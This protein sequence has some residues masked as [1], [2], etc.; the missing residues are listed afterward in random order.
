MTYLNDPD[1]ILP[2]PPVDPDAPDRDDRLLGVARAIVPAW[3][4]AEAAAITTVG[5]G[6]TNLL[7]KLTAPGRPPLLARLYGRNTEV[8]I[9]RVAENRLFAQLSRAGFAPTY[10]GRF[11]G[12]RLEGFLEGF[13]PLE[14]HEMGAPGIREAL[15]ARLAEMHALPAAGPPTLWATLERWM[16]AA[17]GL[18]FEGADAARHAA[19]GLEGAAATLARLRARF[20]AEVAPR[21]GPG[22]AAALRP[23]LAH[24][25]LLSG[26]VLLREATGEVRF[27]DYEY[28]ACSYAGF[29][30]ANHFCE[31]AGFDS[32]FARRFPDRAAREAFAAAYLGGPE[33]VSDFSD[34]VEFFVLPDHLFWGTWAVVQAKHSPIDFD[35]MEYARLRL[36]GLEHHRQVLG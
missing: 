36:A 5:G 19:L 23:V 8:V 29:D 17:R 4:G 1:R 9:D 33:G 35:F 31:Y 7:F 18:T 20:E 28:G 30:V 26:N 13:R 34:V 12:G 11:A 10:H 21:E 32:D 15:A 16:A 14:P 22:A 25:D 6:I 3:A 24:N 2:G 27:I